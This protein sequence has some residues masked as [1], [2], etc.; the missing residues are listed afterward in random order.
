MA[1]Y[2]IAAST[3]D[4][5]ISG[6]SSFTQGD[7]NY[8]GYFAGDYSLWFRFAGIAAAQGDTCASA[9]ITFKVSGAGAGTTMLTAFYGVDEDDH[10]SP[11]TRAEWN[12]DHG[13]HTTAKV[14][15]D[16]T[17]GSTAGDT[18]TS[19]SLVSIFDEIFARAGWATGNAVGIHWENDGMATNIY[20]AI[21]MYE[22]V[23]YTEATLT[24]TLNAGGGGSLKIPVAMQSYRQRR[25]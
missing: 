4:G 12:T 7:P 20:R 13:I 9:Y 6:A 11:T 1:T 14:D 22:S 24:L 5:G 16:F 23:T 2:A 21:A 17:G 25:V 3:D 15:Y 18:L 8:L 10:A 19:P